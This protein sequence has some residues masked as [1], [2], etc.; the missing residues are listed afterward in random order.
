MLAVADTSAV[1]RLEEGTVGKVTSVAAASSVAVTV[2]TDSKNDMPPEND[3]AFAL[4][5]GTGRSAVAA[6]SAVVRLTDSKLGTVTS[7][8]SASAV[9]VT[10]LKVLP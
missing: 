3:A 2:A 1:A 5:L 4:T 6:T 7:A 9:A 8:T 10:N